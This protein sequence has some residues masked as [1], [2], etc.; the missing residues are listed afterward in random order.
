MGLAIAL[1]LVGIILPLS[2]DWTNLGLEKGNKKGDSGL[3]NPLRFL[4]NDFGLD[5]VHGLAS[6]L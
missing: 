4:G 2:S 1:D 6:G 3:L 5:R